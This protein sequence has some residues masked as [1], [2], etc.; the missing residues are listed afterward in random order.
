MKVREEIHLALCCMTVIAD[1]V[2]NWAALRICD[3]MTEL[4]A[5]NREIKERE[6]NG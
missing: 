6:L 2:P 4:L 3:I 1:R 5:L